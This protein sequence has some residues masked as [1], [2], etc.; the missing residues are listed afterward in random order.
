M[1][2]AAGKPLSDL[3]WWTERD[4]KHEAIWE[5]CTRI[6]RNQ[7]ARRMNDLI[8][9]SLYGN[10]PVTG[11]GPFHQNRRIGGAHA[12]L[13]LNVVR[14]MVSAVVSKIAAKNKVKVSFL[15]QGGSH[16][17]DIKRKAEKCEQLVDGVFYD[18]GVYKKQRAIFRDCTVFG[19]GLLKVVTDEQVKRIVADRTPQWEML[20]D[21][22]DG[23]NGEPRSIYQQKPYDKLVLKDM[24]PKFAEQIEKSQ[25]R[26]E[27]VPMNPDT[28]ADVVIA[29]EAWHLPS[30]PD[31]KDGRR[32]IILPEVTLCDDPYDYDTFPF[33]VM[34]WAEDLDGFFG[35]GLAY[36]LAG[37]QAEIND[38]LQEIQEGHHII[39]GFWAVEQGSRVTSQHINDDLSKIIRYAGTRPDYI[40]PSVIAAEVYQHLWNLY[41]K[42]Y[43]ITGISQLTAQSQ[44]PAGL[45][46][47]EALRRYS[48]IVTER[49]LEVGSMLEEWTID[50]AKLTLRCANEIVD[51]HKSFPVVTRTKKSLETLDYADYRLEKGDYEIE[52]FPTSVLPNTPPGRVAFVQDLVNSKM[53]G[54][55][56]GFDLLNFPDTKGY[57]KRRLARR[58][59]FE[60]N[61]ASILSHGE[62][63]PPEPLDDHEFALAELPNVYAEWRDDGVEQAKLELLLRYGT[64]TFRY[65][66]LE[67]VQGPHAAF[68]PANAGAQGAP[69]AVA[70]GAPLPPQPQPGGA[71]PP[72]P[73]AA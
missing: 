13:S 69:Q 43:E 44:K 24:F 53:M 2:E 57:A 52:A 67:Q 4:R 32:C 27:D 65:W 23:A 42:A 72:I 15:P 14:N 38:L 12:R 11:F 58:T 45:N 70:G 62:Y 34:R 41:A 17:Y 28:T 66:K 29:T 8:H 6:R 36:E 10:V 49:F 31:A 50:A 64:M 37:I 46:S 61:V 48:D 1:S 19:T 54:A 47:G 40:V 51:E 60:R 18:R 16:S 5:I 33:A 59:T 63:L 56:D 30:G 55:E 7:D 21:E 35:I 20:V 25:T 73:E 68:D 26:S 3:R 39:T 9:A 71:P 22:T